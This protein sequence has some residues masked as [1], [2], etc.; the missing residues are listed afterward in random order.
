LTQRPDFNEFH[1]LVLILAFINDLVLFKV[2][3]KLAQHLF[4]ATEHRIASILDCCI[5]IQEPSGKLILKVQ[6]GL[7]FAEADR[8]K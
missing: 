7:K 3:D 6:V 4:F 5:D 1:F 8:A 2:S